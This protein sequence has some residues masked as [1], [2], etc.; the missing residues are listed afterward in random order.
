MHYATQKTY[1]QPGKGVYSNDVSVHIGPDGAQRLKLRLPPVKVQRKLYVLVGYEPSGG[2]KEW[3]K[4]DLEVVQKAHPDMRLDGRDS[5]GWTAGKAWE[6]DAHPSWVEYGVPPSWF[7]DLKQG[8]S[9]ETTLTSPEFS[10]DGASKPV[11]YF[12]EMMGRDSQA[13]EA[14][15]EASGDGAHWSKVDDIP[16]AEYYA[17]QRFDLGRWKGKKKVRIRF[18][19]KK[20]D[21][22]IRLFVDSIVVTNDAG[23]QEKGAR[24]KP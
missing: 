24:Q 21:Y 14:V 11:L 12:R 8:D 6:Y 15:V 4:K 19:V 7:C 17:L 22:E 2:G 23:L 5:K 3:T 18:R 1:G 10:L 16:E 13:K 20:G 9:P